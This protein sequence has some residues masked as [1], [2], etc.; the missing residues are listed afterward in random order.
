MDLMISTYDE[1][2]VP[3][4]KASDAEN[5][6]VGAFEK[7]KDQVEEMMSVVR[8]QREKLAKEVEKWCKERG[9]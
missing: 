3:L 7:Y 2:V 1:H 4:L 9:A 5:G 6:G 8:D